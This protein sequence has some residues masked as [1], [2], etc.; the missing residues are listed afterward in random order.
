MPIVKIG[1]DYEK[2]QE[3]NVND[4]QNPMLVNSK[5]FTGYITVRLKNYHNSHEKNIIKNCEYFQ[6]HSR[7]F[8]FQFQGRFKATNPQRQDRYWTFEDVL[9]CAE[10]ENSI[11]P[12][13]GASLA[14]KFGSYIDPSFTAEMYLEKRPWA[15]SWFICGMNVINVWP[16]EK[17]EKISQD[18][19]NYEKETDKF[20][21]N[22]DQSSPPL[23][24]VG[25]WIYHGTN[26]LEEDNKLLIRSE[27]ECNLTSSKR[28]RYFL[29]PE[30]RKS[31]VF[32]P[33]NIYACDFF[34]NFTNFSTMNAEM[35][36][37]FDIT[38]VLKNQPLRFACRNKED[39]IFFVIE[40]DYSD[41]IET[42]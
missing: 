17:D 38:H 5:H 33:A 14:V 25:P 7:F 16:A 12:P 11:Q 4:D 15:G 26:H 18:S 40:I 22:D 42:R 6:L 37:R 34:N 3:Y 35:L 31:S 28:R 9:F 30:I 36:I 13:R 24:P 21:I 41:L 2:L 19:P 23:L 20:D 39:V 10:T 27:K 8:S 1:P 32:D 29:N